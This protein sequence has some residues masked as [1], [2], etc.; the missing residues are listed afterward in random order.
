MGLVTRV[1]GCIFNKGQ[2]LV[3]Q[4]EH[5]GGGCNKGGICG[6]THVN[7]YDFAYG[8]AFGVVDK[9]NPC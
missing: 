3:K 8:M 6:V 2:T 5:V 7:P 4:F 9:V 1:F